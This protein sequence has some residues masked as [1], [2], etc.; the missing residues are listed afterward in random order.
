MQLQVLI[1]HANFTMKLLQCV[2][3]WLL[4][5]CCALALSRTPAYVLPG[6]TEFV[7]ECLRFHKFFQTRVESLPEP[8]RYCEAFAFYSESQHLFC[9][10]F[11]GA[12]SLKGI[13]AW[14]SSPDTSVRARASA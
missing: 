1:P 9:G 8:Q 3:G 14:R 13:A 6:T 7:D 10:A 4:I 11:M 5:S 2:M 12:G